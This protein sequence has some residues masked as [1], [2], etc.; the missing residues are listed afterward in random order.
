M[1]IYIY[2]YIYIYLYMYIATTCPIV[3]WWCG[4]TWLDILDL[5]VRRKQ[6][7]VVLCITLRKGGGGALPETSE[8]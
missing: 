7:E 5:L 2:I 4:L 1:Y 6:K 8:I 3:L